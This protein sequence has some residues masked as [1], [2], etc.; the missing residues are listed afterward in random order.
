MKRFPWTPAKDQELV[1]LVNKGVKSQDIALM[2][3]TPV[4]TVNA[5]CQKLH[6]KSQYLVN[7]NEAHR[8]RQTKL[9]EYFQTHDIHETA[10]HFGL[11]IKT[12]K[13]VLSR[14]YSRIDLIHIRKDNKRHDPWDANELIFALQCA[15]LRDRAWIGA[16]MKRGKGPGIMLKWKTLGVQS[17]IFNG[18]NPVMAKDLTGKK[19]AGIQTKTGQWQKQNYRYLVPWVSLYEEVKEIKDFDPVITSALRA[20]SRWQMILYNTKTVQETID[21]MEAIVRKK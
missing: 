18:V 5:R 2:F 9:F 7:R 16:T 14:A 10:E 21:A 11:S 12:T 4:T 6:L 8:V 20:M 19:L 15:G 13:A 1:E 3:G 17:R